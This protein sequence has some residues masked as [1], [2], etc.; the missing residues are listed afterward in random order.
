MLIEMKVYGIAIDP[1]T[2]V[3]IVILRDAEGKNTLPIWI[4]APEASAIVLEVE[5]LSFSR[6][7]TH[8]LMKDLLSK[9]AVTITRV[10]VVDLRDGVYYARIHL[11][12]PAGETHADA[13]PSD[14]I[15]LALRAGAPI[16]VEADVIEKSK[17]LDVGGKSGESLG[18][19]EWL[20]SLDEMTPDEFG[21]YKM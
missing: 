6:P 14:A 12:T 5:K 3:P 13:R 19:D 4:G 9:A 8:D 10:E 20:K 7:M 11:S 1:T 21:K 16:L 18:S 2:S 17:D 15:A